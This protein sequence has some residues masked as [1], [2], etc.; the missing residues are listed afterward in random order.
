MKHDQQTQR[1]K[2]TM[3]ALKWCPCRGP[4]PQ[5]APRVLHSAHP[6]YQ[7]FSWKCD[8]LYRKMFLAPLA[9]NTTTSCQKCASPHFHLQANKGLIQKMI[10]ASRM[11]LFAGAIPRYGKL[12][13][14]YKIWWLNNILK[15]LQMKLENTIFVNRVPQKIFNKR[16]WIIWCFHIHYLLSK[17][18]IRDMAFKTKLTSLVDTRGL[19][20][21]AFPKSSK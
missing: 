4:P 3:N 1:C 17:F 16:I 2:V 10:T 19:T 7:C 14:I 15:E 5:H 20:D 21:S 18:A 13:Y 8:R 6:S 12:C 11:N 9:A